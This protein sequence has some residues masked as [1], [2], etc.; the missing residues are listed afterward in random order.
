MTREATS[1]DLKVREEM[2][3][4]KQREKKTKEEGT[5]KH[6]GAQ[7]GVAYVGVCQAC[8]FAL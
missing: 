7:L 1:C 8:R 6:T 2:G 3:G 4:E 5:I